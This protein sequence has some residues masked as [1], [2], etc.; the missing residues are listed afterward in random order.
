MGVKLLNRFIIANCPEAIR[1]LKFSELKNMK[2][3]VDTS[4][5]MYKFA[6][7]GTLIEN[8]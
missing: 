6:T 3:V 7:D 5:Y 2:I 4:I 1:Q 8:I